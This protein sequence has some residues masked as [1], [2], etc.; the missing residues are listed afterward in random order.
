MNDT[1]QILTDAT[2][3]TGPERTIAPERSAT[4]F[5]RRAALGIGAVAL[6]LAMATDALAVAGRHIGFTF[7]G[8]IEIFEACV[9]I[10]A[11]SAIVIATIDRSHARVRILL[12]QVGARVAGALDRAADL[13]SA[14][15][16]VVLIAGSVW[17]AS[18]LWNGHEVTEVL[19]L[20]V[21][22]LRVV[23]IVGAVLA[24][25]IFTGQAVRRRA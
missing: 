23:W 4:A 9:V 15:V 14:A 6:L 5:V 25:T 2:T 21:R 24:A 7:L 22:W 10:A 3:P 1:D 8:A 16:F 20:P 19:N 13:V 12:E 17:L 11:T 18:D